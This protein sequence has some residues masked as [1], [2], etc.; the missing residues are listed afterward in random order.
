MKSLRIGIVL[1]IA[2]ATLAP[3]WADEKA[4]R[5]VTTFAKVCLAKPDS[6]SAMNMLAASQGFAL[7]KPDAA[8]LA[9]KQVDFFNLLLNWKRRV[10]DSR[11]RLTGLTSGNVDR[12]EL[13]C[14]L[15]GYGVPA[16]DVVAAL[17]PML[18]EPARRTVKENDWIEL[19][20]TATGDVTLSFKEGGQ[21]QRLSLTL[22]QL[23]GNWAQRK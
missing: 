19:A 8:A 10:D 17:K 5:L 21:G 23:F 3:A 12:Y 15:D 20:W 7:D 9:D 14:V 11:M 13:G 6:M 18:G 16:P 4:D 22:V 1:L 2:A